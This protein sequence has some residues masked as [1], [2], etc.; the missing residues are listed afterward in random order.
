[1]WLLVPWLLVS[2]IGR[3]GAA[4][5]IMPGLNWVRLADA[6]SCPTAAQ[7]GASVEARL[8][9]ELFVVARE[10]QLFLDGYVARS[11]AGFEV[12]L[13]VSELA[14]R[15]LGRRVLQF[16]GD[17]CSAIEP[18]VALVIAVTLNP[19]SALPSG[20][21]PLE[22]G[23]A[24]RLDALFAGESIDPDPASLPAPNAGTA[25]ARTSN[26]T[27]LPAADSGDLGPRTRYEP[28]LV[29]LAAAGGAGLG[30]LPGVALTGSAYA[31]L[32]FP[33]GPR[34]ELGISYLPAR[35]ARPERGAGEASFA[36][37]LG[38]LAVC[39]LRLQ[40]WSTPELCFGAELGS[41][42][43][44]ARDFAFA[45]QSAHDWVVNLRASGGW[46]VVLAAPLFMRVAVLLSVPLLQR[47][48]TF[49]GPDNAPV[50]L[51]RMP[52]AA[53]RAELGLGIA[54]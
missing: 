21:I 49:R 8:G 50:S 45:N 32:R 23:T 51:F 47:N 29:E 26:E 31:A 7:I 17:D 30:Q 33:R 3:A 35:T 13:E 52:Q 36:L 54:F 46:D 14:G 53:A 25:N 39:P 44:H 42:S 41:L 27:P 37:L 6:D 11:V 38:S 43:S 18:A 16:E 9:R 15:V 5:P 22:H 10:A 24:E 40:V 1:L 4:E 28:V 34:I 2:Q 12:T 20:G 48:Y 19:D